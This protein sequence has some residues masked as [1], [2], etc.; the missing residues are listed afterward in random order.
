[1]LIGVNSLISRSDAA[2]ENTCIALQKKKKKKKRQ[3]IDFKRERFTIS[4][5]PSSTWHLRA[6]VCRLVRIVSIQWPD[7]LAKVYENLVA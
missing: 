5:L 2:T 4:P 6:F 7:F 1:M 3:L